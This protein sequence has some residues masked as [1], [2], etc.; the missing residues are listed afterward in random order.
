MDTSIAINE[1]F[2]WD[3]PEDRWKVYNITEIAEGLLMTKDKKSIKI[4]I[5]K[6]GKKFKYKTHR[7]TSTGMKPKTGFL[8]PPLVRDYSNL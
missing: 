7:H 5:E 8:L 2:N 3:A 1:G 4:E 6:M